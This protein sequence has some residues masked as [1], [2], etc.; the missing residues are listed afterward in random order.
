MRIRNRIARNDDY[1][2]FLMHLFQECGVLYQAQDICGINGTLI[3]PS[4]P[5]EN[6]MMSLLQD[7]PNVGKVTVI[8]KSFRNTTFSSVSFIYR[9]TNYSINN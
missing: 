2:L 4:Y 7:F 8:L 5:P 3:G 9:Y 1:N 6:F